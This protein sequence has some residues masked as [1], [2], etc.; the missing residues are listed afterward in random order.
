MILIEEVIPGTSCAFG[1][2]IR[3]LTFRLIQGFL[4]LFAIMLL[5]H[6][7]G[8]APSQREYLGQYS[9]RKAMLKAMQSAIQEGGEWTKMNAAEDASNSMGN[10]ISKFSYLVV[11]DDWDGIQE[12]HLV[13]IRRKGAER[14]FLHRVVVAQR[15]GIMTAGDNNSRSDAWSV[16]EEYLGT[17]AEIIPYNPAL[18]D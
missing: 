14:P 9:Q 8:E 13:L 17:V 12:D 1:Y 16:R 10:T 11:I 18:K 6:G 3:I 2:T 7:C 15:D 4:A 5:L